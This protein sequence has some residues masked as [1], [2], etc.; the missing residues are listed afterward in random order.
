MWRPSLGRREHDIHLSLR[1]SRRIFSRHAL[2]PEPLYPSSRDLKAKIDKSILQD[3][4]FISIWHLPTPLTNSFMA[5]TTYISI[6][7]WLKGQVLSQIAPKLLQTRT[8]G[9]I[10]I[11]DKQS[12]QDMSCKKPPAEGQMQTSLKSSN[13]PYLKA[14]WQTFS[15]SN[16]CQ[17]RQTLRIPL[18]SI[19]CQHC[20]ANHETKSCTKLLD[21]W[22]MLTH[23]SLQHTL[24]QYVTWPDVKEQ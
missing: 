9:T 2:L 23:K 22:H 12:S 18:S 7:Y 10:N 14:L 3:Y 17:I 19:H 13:C 20:R 11:L 8:W 6:M 16:F 24:A 4:S 1:R 15:W 5:H 21:T